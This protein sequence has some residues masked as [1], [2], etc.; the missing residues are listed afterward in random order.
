MPSWTALSDGAGR[1]PLSGCAEVWGSLR[2]VLIVDGQG[3]VLAHGD[4]SSCSTREALF[5]R[6]SPLRLSN[7]R[8]RA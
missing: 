8:C 4:M 2:T 5:A 1:R 7:G 6:F 3:T